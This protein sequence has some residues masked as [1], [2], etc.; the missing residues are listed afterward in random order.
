MQAVRF[1][2]TANITAIIWKTSI[3]GDKL[4]FCRFGMDLFLLLLRVGLHRQFGGSVN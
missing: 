4:I 3:F 2:E 1:N